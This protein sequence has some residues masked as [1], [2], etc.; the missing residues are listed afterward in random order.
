VT[1]GVAGTDGRQ[2]ALRALADA[3]YTVASAELL[4]GGRT[5]QAGLTT[6]ADEQHVVELSETVGTR[7]DRE[8]TYRIQER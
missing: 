8:L 1:V 5:P 2:R 4:D 3:G 6:L 7:H